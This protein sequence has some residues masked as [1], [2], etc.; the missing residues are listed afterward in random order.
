[1]NLDSIRSRLTVGYVGIF[2]LVLLLLGVFAVFGFS[3][4]LVLQ[5]DELLAQEARNTT[6]N[7]LEGNKSEVLAAKSPEFGWIALDRDGGVMDRNQTTTSLGLP[8]EDL[9]QETLNGEEMVVATVQGT[10]GNARVV[11]IPMYESGE[12]VGVMQY[13][14]SL[15]RVQ[16][17][18]SE[19]IFVLLPLGLG[20]LGLAAVG[21]LYMAGRAVKPVREAFDRQ[22]AFI[23]DASHELKT[24]LTLVRIDMEVLQSNLENPDDRELAD[25]VLAE[26]DRMSL[27]LSDL[28]TMTRLDANV[29]D[30]ARKP[31][32]LS[33]LLREETERFKM[34]ATREGV[35]LEVRVPDE[36]LASGDP[37]RT[38]QILAAL[39]DN[40][41]RFTPSGGSV[42]VTAREQDGRVEAT[43]SDTGPGVPSEH[44]PRIF[45]RFYR[46]EA[47]RSRS[48]AGGGTGIGLSIAQGLARAQEGDLEAENAKDGGA[49]F[50]LKLPAG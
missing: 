33:N 14:R 49:V 34:R 27:I 32:D 36:L 2:G 42:E 43:V 22:R 24:P 46:A 1:V 44:L 7:L 41:L 4:E 10:N 15:R 3:R 25:E 50:R 38:G 39:L 12:L 23:G 48:E 31:F 17:N 8:S 18:V 45:E 29:L 19:L 16:K 47:A 20:A 30:V 11:S 9:F 5:Q 28:L 35:R 6:K 26:T 13:A 40:A 37:A 21:G